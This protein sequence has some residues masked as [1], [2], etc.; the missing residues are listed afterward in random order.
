MYA[1]GENYLETILRLYEENGSVRSVDVARKL[2]V[3]RPSVSRAMGLLKQAGYIEA[4]EKG[5]IHLTQKGFDAAD[6]IYTKHR[7]LTAFLASIAGVSR[8]VAEENACRIEHIIDEEVFA[9]IIAF[10]RERSQGETY[11]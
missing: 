11:G 3:S 4:E 2:R 10:M 8:S 1:S 7:C 6:K 5:A 9:G